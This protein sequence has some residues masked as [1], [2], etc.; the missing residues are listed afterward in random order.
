[1]DPE[2]SVVYWDAS[3]VLSVLF[4]DA[5]SKNALERANMEGIHFMSSLA[6]AEVCA[7][8]ARMKNEEII[9]DLVES[10]SF[11]ALQQGPWHLLSTSPGWE[12][13]RTLSMK[14]SLRGADL[15]HLATAKT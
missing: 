8:I 4:K 14:W 13:T 3:A 9:S 2:F 5:Q 7:V 12:I 1:M 15:W 11:E 10:T 6:W